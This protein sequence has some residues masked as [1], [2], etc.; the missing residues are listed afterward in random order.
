MKVLSMIVSFLVVF[1]GL[2]LLAA[3]QSSDFS[4]KWIP[5]LKKSDLKA[6]NIMGPGNSGVSDPSGGGGMG[7]MGG[8]MGGMGGMGGGGGF[9]GGMGG[10]P[11]SKQQAPQTLPPITIEQTP[12]NMQISTVMVFNGV[13]G[14][15]YVE[16]YALDRKEDLV[17]KVT[18]AFTKKEEQKRTKISL[19]KN[20]LQTRVITEGQYGNTET[21]KTYELSSD[22]KTL[23]MEVLNDMGMMG[24]TLQKIV[25]TKE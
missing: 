1:A 16:N 7:G 13:E 22:G 14:P 11:K 21:K 23:T 17:E 20:K 24:Q 2:N 8:G 15:P 19:K 10:G 25:Y 9:G 3:D 6:K 18:N 4:G 12:T 5:D